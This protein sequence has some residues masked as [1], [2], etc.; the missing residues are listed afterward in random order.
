MY[1][2]YIFGQQQII[3]ENYEIVSQNKVTDK[4]RLIANIPHILTKII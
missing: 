1:E 3:L 2:I 4:F